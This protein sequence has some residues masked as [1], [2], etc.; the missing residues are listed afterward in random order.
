MARFGVPSVRNL[1]SISTR[2]VV[3]WWLLALTSIPLHLLYNSAVFSTLSV[4]KYQVYI[5]SSDFIDGAAF[6]IP[7]GHAVFL[8]TGTA[9]AIPTA[10]A[11]ATLLRYQQNL[12]SLR[13]L[14]NPECIKAYRQAIQSSYTDVVLVSSATN[15]GNS[16][17]DIYF[18]VGPS[19]SSLDLDTLVTNSWMCDDPTSSS[20][21]DFS[22]L[23]DNAQYWNVT[24]PGLQ[25]P[26]DFSEGNVTAPI[27]Y[28]L[29][30]P[31]EAQCKL[32]LSL[33]IILIV[34]V[35]NLVKAFC[36]GFVAWEKNTNPLVTVGDAIASFLRHPDPSTEGNCIVG[37]AELWHKQE[38]PRRPSK[39]TQETTRWYQVVSTRR[40]IAC[41]FL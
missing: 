5:V 21:C 28:C 15:A 9:S 18:D 19:S 29:T 40:R 31:R 6:D 30:R 12:S 27:Q 10:Q 36:I 32:E 35:C 22:S 23:A 7:D 34:V 17:I 25:N 4:Q 8:G 1:R 13:T 3:F 20:S 2:R 14:E 26:A 24:C 41:I 38:W 16:L 39:W 11:Q 37:K 33:A